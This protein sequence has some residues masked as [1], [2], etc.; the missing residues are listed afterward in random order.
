VRAVMRATVTAAVL[1]V[2]HRVA[3][4]LTMPL[5]AAQLGGPGADGTHMPPGSPQH[6]ARQHEQQWQARRLRQQGAAKQEHESTQGINLNPTGDQQHPA[7]SGQQ[8][9]GSA[10]KGQGSSSMMLRCLL[11]C[12]R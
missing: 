12:L 11:M 10:G 7:S 2:M 6:L 5:E 3:A 4:V 9:T 1:T 8:Y